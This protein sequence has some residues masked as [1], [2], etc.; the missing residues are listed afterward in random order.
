MTTLTTTLEQ[1][2]TLVENLKKENENLQQQVNYLKEQLAW[3][4][5]QI[6]G[7]RS[8]KIVFPN[9]QEQLFP[10]FKFPS[11]PEKKKK[12]LQLISVALIK[13]ILLSLHFQKISP[14]SGLL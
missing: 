12:K 5:K 2:L 4:T 10:G 3:F 11:V 6:F 7:K 1:S 9:T 13:T 8:E 14:L